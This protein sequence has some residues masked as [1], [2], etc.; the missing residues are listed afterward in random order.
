ATLAGRAFGGGLVPHAHTGSPAN[1][2]CPWDQFDP[3]WYVDHNYGVLREDDK[4]I[5]KWMRDFFVEFLGENRHYRGIDLGAGANLYPALAMLPFC[6][7][8]TLV[9]RGAANRRWLRREISGP[10]GYRGTWDPFW[11]TLAEA[12][13]Y[14]RCADPRKALRDRA[15]VQYGDVFQLARRS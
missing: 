3:E 15:R 7:E 5:L 13:P 2:D 4:D 8:I 10:H 9:E 12:E 11:E 6:D 1:V 14:A